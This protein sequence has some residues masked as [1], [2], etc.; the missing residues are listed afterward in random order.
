MD[1]YHLPVMLEECLDALKLGPQ[2]VILDC[3]L[4]GGGHFS[5]ISRRLG[6]EGVVLGVDRDSDAIERAEIYCKD[7]PSKTAVGH[8]PFSQFPDLIK[9]EGFT[10]VDGILMDLGVSSHQFDAGERGFS[11]RADAPLDMRM[12][13]RSGESAADIINEADEERLI[14]I[15]RD[16]GEVRNPR[17]MVG[18]IVAARKIQEIT[19]TG[20]LLTVLNAEY[21]DLKK[22]VLSKIF[23]G[24]RIA[25]NKELEELDIALAEA[26]TWLNPGGRLVIMS[27]HSLE[28]RIVK[29]FYRDAATGCT[30]PPEILQCVCEGVKTMKVITRKPILPTEAE[31]DINRRARSAKLRVAERR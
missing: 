23:Q 5:E 2:K 16:Y 21:G 4:G 29:N 11:Y 27:Y 31:I 15:L 26:I 7:L 13:Q 1:K 3:T 14:H 20:E 25:V 9:G 24:F 6:K 8:H 18:V 10:G 28:D 19:T 12:D 22:G 17:R 30:C